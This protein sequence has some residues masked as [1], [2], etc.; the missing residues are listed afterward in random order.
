LPAEVSGSLPVFMEANRLARF[1]GVGRIDIVENRFVGI[2]S[3]GFVMK[4][5]NIIILT[6]LKHEFHL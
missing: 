6:S 5:K 4:F 2:K 1:H 3:R